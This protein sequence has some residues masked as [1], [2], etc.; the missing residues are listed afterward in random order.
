MQHF[1][2]LLCHPCRTSKVQILCKLLASF[3]PVYVMSEVHSAANCTGSCPFGFSIY[4]MQ[5]DVNLNS[6]Q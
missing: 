1:P 3:Q 2:G 4:A 6:D 5:G